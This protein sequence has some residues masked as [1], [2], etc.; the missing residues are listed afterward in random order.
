MI[1]SIR[2]RNWRSHSD[3]SLEFRDGTNLLIGAMGSGKSSVLDALSFALF[4]TFPAL[5]RRKMKLQDLFRLNEDSTSVNLELSWNGS[6]YRVERGL[7]KGKQKVDSEARLFRDGSMLES[8]PSAV[9]EYISQILGMDYDLF[10]RA[11]YS[12][13]NGIDYFLTLDPRRRKQEIDALLGLDRF[14]IARTNIVSV[15]NRIKSNRKLLEDRLDPSV[16]SKTK[17]RQVQLE[18]ELESIKIRKKDLLAIEAQQ[19]MEW[20]KYESDLSEMKNKKEEHER[21]S[22]E[23]LRLETVISQLKNEIDG[24]SLDDKLLERLR[25]GL[26]EKKVLLQF[27]KDQMATIDSTINSLSRDA[28]AISARK[29][30]AEQAAADLEKSSKELRELLGKESFEVFERRR[31]QAEADLISAITEMNALRASV[32]ES[33]Q[34]LERIKPGSSTC[35]LCESD[36]GEN[37]AKH[38]AEEKNKK[39]TFALS[40]IE[41]LERTATEKKKAVEELSLRQKKAVSLLALISSIEKEALSADKDGKVLTEIS[42]KLNTTR[43]EKESL[44][45]KMT[46]IDQQLQS[47]LFE[48]N[49]AEELHKKRGQF[50]EADKKAA[51]CNSRIVELGFQE[52]LYE[53]LRKKSEQGSL[54]LERTTSELR[55]LGTQLGMVEEMDSRLKKE[56]ADMEAL[57]KDVLRY[58]VLEADLALYR[59]ALL[60]TQTSLRATLT[61]AINSAMKEVWPLFYPHKNYSSIRLSVSDR[62]YNLEVKEGEDWKTLESVSSGGERACAALTLRAALAV[63]LAPNLSWLILDE[64]THNLDAEAVS[65]LSETLQTRVPEVV[66]QIFVITHDEGLIGA[67]FSTSYRLLRDKSSFGPTQIERI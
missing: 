43:V 22:R 15:L 5:E 60:E 26:K 6:V 33:K 66:K 63:V 23:K 16:Q 36:L 51:F 58:A 46:E 29:K 50:E 55:A 20:K 4:G 34:L 1:N 67:D 10:A 57:A 9:N 41:A 18:K 21:L 45:L 59:N 2:L 32:N 53:E 35:P 40:R 42:D 56:L 14:E 30:R 44:S 39:I 64:P 31:S 52:G 12:E 38:V 48:I 65:M 3:S 47:L 13:Q 25:T 11:V 28:G 19:K 37:G 62:D 27:T 49:K 54:L 24:K 17:E 8:G 7:K 61:E